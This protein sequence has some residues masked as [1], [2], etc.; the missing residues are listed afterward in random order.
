MRAVIRWQPFVT[1]SAVLAE[2]QAILRALKPDEVKAMPTSSPAQ[3]LRE[4]ALRLS[5]L[6]DEHPD[7]GMS[8]RIE[9]L[10][11]ELEA[12]AVALDRKD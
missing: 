10:A 9:E 3:Q 12:K 1:D 7:D 4:R 2:L 5:E 6:A 8:R 11:A